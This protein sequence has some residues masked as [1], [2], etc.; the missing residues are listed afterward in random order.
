MAKL[1]AGIVTNPAISD[2]SARHRLGSGR[3]ARAREP[4]V[5]E[6]AVVRE[7]EAARKGEEAEAVADAEEEETITRPARDSEAAP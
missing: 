5:V 7:A 6:L 3:R 1:F 2:T 4:R